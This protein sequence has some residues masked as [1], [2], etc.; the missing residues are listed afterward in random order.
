MIDDCTGK[1]EDRSSYLFAQP[2][3][4]IIANRPEEVA[5]ALRSI[6][7]YL[8]SGKYTAGYI[9]YEVGLVVDKFIISRHA[10]SMPLIWM[11]V[12]G[13]Y[14]RYDANTI[15]VGTPEDIDDVAD[16]RLN[17]TEDQYLKDIA[18]IKRYIAA[19]DVY[20]VNYTCKLLFKHKATA[21]SL[22]A[23]LRKA[24]P[25]AHSA[26]VNLGDTQVISLSPE[27]FVR[28]KGYH[29]L[30]RP[31]KGTSPRGMWASQDELFA[32][33]LAEDPKQRAE[34][35]M[36]VDL[37]RNDI[38]RVAR[39]GSVNV[40]RLFHIEK[41]ESLLQMTS[42]VEAHLRPDVD[43]SE[44][45]RNIFPA[46]S[47]TGAPKIR[48]MEI[49]NELEHDNRG[50]YCGGIGMF[51]PNRDCLLNVA[52]RT[53]IKRGESCEMGAGSGIVADSD[54][55]RELEETRL[56]G[57][58]LMSV[59]RDFELLETLLYESGKGYAFLEEHLNRIQSSARYFG[60][61]IEDKLLTNTLID[62]SARVDRS[63]IKIA[64]VRLLVSRGG[65]AR[66]EWAEIGPILSTAAKLLL[67]NRAI[68]PDNVF[69]YHKTTQRG[70]YDSDLVSARDNG[71]VDMIYLNTKG[72][73]TECSIANVVVEIGGRLYTPPVGCGLLPGVWRQS[74]VS[75]G[76]VTE[77]KLTISDLKY[78][79]RVMI[80]NSVR[81][82]TEISRIDD[83][84]GDCVWQLDCA[85]SR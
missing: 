7:M 10:P 75:N 60:W 39:M 21:G 58:F 25:V 79:N 45:I 76:S 44:L 26:F 4:L 68:D 17:I 6:D 13:N 54:G 11:G 64:R 23:R 34:N 27:L 37:M 46:G 72:E 5:D 53:I 73:I 20:Q 12:Y 33:R 31:M 30:T 48:A 85:E 22:F 82:E 69:L 9:G 41:Y 32:R 43:A 8:D 40:P 15:N 1:R 2:E 67:S 62:T 70:S 80:C 29:I 63:G 59:P 61:K 84:A 42:D 57:K 74:I 38:G 18:R 36:I 19:G 55:I 56:K 51:G 35:V 14:E 65:A 71:Y 28:R 77:R 49:I 16:I 3:A 83:G 66:T 78:A 24:H 50:V 47:I 81:G 52:I